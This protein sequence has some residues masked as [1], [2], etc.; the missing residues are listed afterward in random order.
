MELVNEYRDHDAEW[1]NEVLDHNEIVIVVA[2]NNNANHGN[3]ISSP[4]KGFNVITVGN[5]NDATDTINSSSCYIDPETGIN[6]PEV[7]AP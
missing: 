5:Y 2:G 6:K 1:D 4:G 3:E 7:S